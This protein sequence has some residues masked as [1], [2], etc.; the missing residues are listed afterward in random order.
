[1]TADKDTENIQACQNFVINEQFLISREV[2][3][4]KQFAD[5]LEY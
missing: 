2:K 3:N 1:M 5:L 4:T